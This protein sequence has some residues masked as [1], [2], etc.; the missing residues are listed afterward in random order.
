MNLE[1]VSF[2]VELSS[3]W[4]MLLQELEVYPRSYSSSSVVCNEYWLFLQI[5]GKFTGIRLQ[6]LRKLLTAQEYS[7]Y[8]NG[9]YP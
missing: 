5:C 1:L 4:E 3:L 8:W 9:E 2:Y 7:E 6:M